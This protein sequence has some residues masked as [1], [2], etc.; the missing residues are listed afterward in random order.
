MSYVKDAWRASVKN[1]A[2]PRDKLAPIVPTQYDPDLEGPAI[3]HPE[4]ARAV[5][6]LLTDAYARGIRELKVKYSYRTLAKQ[7]EKYANYLDGGNLAAYPGT[8]NHGWGVS[9]DFTGLTFKALQFLRS[10]ADR[11]GF[12]NDVPSENWH[13]TYQ[14]G[15]EPEDEMTDEQ[16]A[17]LRESDQRWDGM[18]AY[19]G[20]PEATAQPARNRPKAFKEGWNAAKKL[21]L[22]P[23]G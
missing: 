23:R 18:L 5:S 21:A 22:R 8:S 9:V 3:L 4:A 1:G 17:K 6:D 12:V 20:Q 16:L 7:Q 14:G 10:H 19:L 15:Y 13:Y 2:I 11:Y